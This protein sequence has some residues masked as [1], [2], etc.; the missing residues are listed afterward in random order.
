MQDA[1]ASTSKAV[2][3]LGAAAP[4]Y[5]TGSLGAGATSVLSVSAITAHGTGPAASGAIEIGDGAG[6]P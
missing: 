4:W 1:T 3:A 6:H 5:T 2:T